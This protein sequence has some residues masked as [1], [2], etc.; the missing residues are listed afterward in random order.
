[1]ERVTIY[2]K[3][4]NGINDILKIVKATMWGYILLFCLAVQSIFLISPLLFKSWIYLKFTFN[5]FLTVPML[6]LILP[7]M[8]NCSAT[9]VVTFY[10]ILQFISLVTLYFFIRSKEIS[11][12]N[13]FLAVSNLLFFMPLSLNYSAKL[14]MR[15]WFFV[16]LPNKPTTSVYYVPLHRTYKLPIYPYM[17]MFALLFYVFSYHF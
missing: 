17:V 9:A 12:L 13:L 16:V 6:V 7:L 14:I 1:M 2:E 5:K 11:R 3:S 15:S 10:W 8:L 4:E